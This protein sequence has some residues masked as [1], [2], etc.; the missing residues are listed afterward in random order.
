MNGQTGGANNT[1]FSHMDID[2]LGHMTGNAEFRF[3]ASG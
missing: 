3:T 2:I 1:A